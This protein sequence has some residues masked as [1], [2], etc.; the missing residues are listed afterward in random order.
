MAW[1]LEQVTIEVA[2]DVSRLTEKRGLYTVSA[3]DIS[4]VKRCSLAVL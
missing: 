2:G 3:P 4:I 1:H